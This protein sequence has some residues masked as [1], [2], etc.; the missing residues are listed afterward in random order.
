MR[1]QQ[2]YQRIEDVMSDPT[3]LE[4]LERQVT[5]DPD[6][7]DSQRSSVLTRIGRYQGDLDRSAATDD[8]EEPGLPDDDGL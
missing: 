7:S 2:Y 6:L 3:D 4:E 1:A 8:G 5:A